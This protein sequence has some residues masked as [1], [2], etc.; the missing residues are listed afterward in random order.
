MSAVSL[1]TAH[2]E[3]ENALPAILAAA[4]YAFRRWRFQDREEAI[5]ETTAAAWS[6]WHGLL[7]RGKN[8]SEVGVTGIA[9]NA[10]RYVKNGRRVGNRHCGR[11]A[12][13]IWHPR[14]QRECGLK[15]VSF[16]SSPRGRREAWKDWIVIDN[17]VRPSAE[18]AFR[19]DFATWLDRLPARKREMAL[20]L[21]EGHE[22]GHVAKTLSVTPAAVSQTRSW[23]AR[24]WSEF[25]GEQESA[26]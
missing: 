19:L 24:S 15:I 16:D 1:T 7:A 9:Q 12:M 18:A 11:G 5:A 22:T 13:D 14:V 25:Q 21:S 3:F 2:Q 26:S 17:R 20:M 8:A 23:L 10:C 4:R 6:A